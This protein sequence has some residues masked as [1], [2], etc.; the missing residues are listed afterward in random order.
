MLD[1]ERKTSP[2]N[3]N[4]L[5]E[6]LFGN[7]VSASLSY[8]GA[9]VDW[10]NTSWTVEIRE[11][12]AYQLERRVSSLGEDARV[13]INIRRF[14]QDAAIEWFLELENPSVYDSGIF[15]EIDEAD[16]EFRF[17]PSL[18]PFFYDSNGSAEQLC[19]FMTHKTQMFHRAHRN[20]AAEG[21]RSS[22]YT[23]PYFNLAVDGYGY[24]IAIGWS[25]QWRAQVVRPN[26]DGLIR[27]RAGMED[28]CFRLHPGEKV[29][30]PRMLILRW[31]GSEHEGY[32]A[33]RRFAFR[34]IVPKIG[35]K[36]VQSPICLSSWG[37]APAQA[38]LADFAVIRKHNLKGD[39][40]WIDAGW[41]GD[42]PPT[43]GDDGSWYPYVGIN[44]WSP[45]PA[46]YP[47][48]M[49]EVADGARAAGIEFLLWYGPGRCRTNAKRAMEH[50]EWYLGVHKPNSDLLLNLGHPEAR[51]WLTELLKDHIR[52][53]QMKVLRI[54]FNFGPLPF[55]RY[56]DTVDRKGISELKY[57]EGLY[58]LWDDLLAEFPKLVID[59]CASGGRRL[60]YEALRRSIPLFRSD[61]ACFGKKAEPAGYQLQT[62][63]LNT[64]VAVHATSVGVWDDDAYTFRSAFASGITM[65]VPPADASEETFASF[66]RL[67]GQA[68]RMRP[69]MSGDYWPLT[70]FSY[71]EKDWMAYQMNLPESSSGMVVAFRRSESATPA[72]DFELNG[73]DPEGSYETEDLDSGVVA[74]VLG[75]TLCDGLRL[76]LPEK[77]SSR[78]VF[79]RKILS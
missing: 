30:L 36:P 51:K 71:S 22:S 64:M 55:W 24:I 74:R 35:G 7:R 41:Y 75:K 38:H 68:Y 21:G 26:D 23:M 8:D 10:S 69:Y 20:M 73:I 39:V 47:N 62:Y 42:A 34:N 13:A 12:E 18:T 4:R 70:G 1:M 33:Y 57:I 56:G 63:C 5:Y 52:R 78:I 29:A 32:N 14:R 17:E 3:G 45:N 49:E 31:E 60:D 72:M 50:P 6:E 15:S 77:R 28:G 48:G 58:R 37:G 46:L 53:L 67:I 27:F 16:V 25:G 9:P 40:Y 76:E 11:E 19:D 54:D 59:N 2:S 79:Y 43:A 44:D 61:Y 65:S 66:R